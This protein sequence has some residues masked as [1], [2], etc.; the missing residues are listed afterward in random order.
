MHLQFCTKS[1]ISSSAPVSAYIGDCV[2]TSA[3]V[4]LG[5]TLIHLKLVSLIFYAIIS[6]IDDDVGKKKKITHMIYVMLRCFRILDEV[7]G[8]ESVKYSHIHPPICLLRSSCSSSFC[9][10]IFNFK[11]SMI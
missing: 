10:L 6:S 11:H 1:A 5:C 9:V 8:V 7:A 3:E 2:R 4:W